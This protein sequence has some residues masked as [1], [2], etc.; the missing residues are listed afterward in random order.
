MAQMHVSTRS[1][2]K[3]TAVAILPDH[4]RVVEA[5]RALHAAGFGNDQISILAKDDQTVRETVDQIGVLNGAEIEAADDLA[6]ESIPK[7]RD[8]VGGMA[9][10]AGVGFVIS[11][12]AIAIPGFGEF[13][14]A[15]G[16]LAL[17]VNALTTSAAGVGLGALVGALMD[18]RGTEAHRDL[19]KNAL[20]KGQW[21]LVV[22][23]D[24]AQ[25]DQA[26]QVLRTGSLEHLDTF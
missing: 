3:R 22:H 18:E 5:V 1:R 23:G 11:F 9:I 14:L 12:T 20:E 2:H 21:L 19:Y 4:T 13:L 17:A 10:G 26:A 7:G 25:I 16:P 15:A 24:N 8:E 6:E